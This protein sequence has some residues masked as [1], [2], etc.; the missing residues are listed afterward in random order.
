MLDSFEMEGLRQLKNDEISVI[1]LDRSQ[2]QNSRSREKLLS[3]TM[4]SSESNLNLQMLPL[5]FISILTVTFGCLMALQTGFFQQNI[6]IEL[7][8]IGLQMEQIGLFLSIQ[9]LFFLL[10]AFIAQK[11][12]K[13]RGKKADI[14][15]YMITSALISVGG[16]ILAGPSNFL[17]LPQNL[18]LMASGQAILGLSAAFT[19]LFFLTQIMDLTY[20]PSSGSSWS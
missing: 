8:Q 7:R 10:G 18:L 1:E 17:N 5:N 19:T 6:A 13:N 3:K 12:I 15:A 11:I 9:P 2:P 14:S 20:W 16:T 4:D